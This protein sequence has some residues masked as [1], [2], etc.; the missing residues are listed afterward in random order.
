MKFNH[1]LSTRVVDRF[2]ISSLW[3]DDTL[4]SYCNGKKEYLLRN[5]TLLKSTFILSG[6][7]HRGNERTISDTC[8]TNGKTGHGDNHS[9]IVLEVTGSDPFY[10]IRL[11]F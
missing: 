10:K 2:S 7:S 8:L 1:I 9:W 5:E 11:L 4:N 6:H 3:I